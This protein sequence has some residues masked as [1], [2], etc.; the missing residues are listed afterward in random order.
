MVA[1]VKAD[2]GAGRALTPV[3]AVRPRLCAELLANLPIRRRLAILGRN[4]GSRSRT[5]GG[6]RLY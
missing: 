6:V 1:S 5:V 4:C 2:P 3:A